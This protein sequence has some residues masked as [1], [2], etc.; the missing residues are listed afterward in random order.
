MQHVCVTR[1]YDYLH[2]Q[3][4]TVTWLYDM[5]VLLSASLERMVVRCKKGILGDSA[6]MGVTTRFMSVY[7]GQYLG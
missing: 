7:V 3:R 2:L 4:D 6:Q 5:M 1:W